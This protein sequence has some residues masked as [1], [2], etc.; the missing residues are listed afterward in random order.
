MDPTV[1]RRTW[2]LLEPRALGVRRFRCPA[3]GPSLLLR[4]AAEETAIRCLRCRAS[5][6]T[7]SLLAALVRHRL[8]GSRVHA[9]ETS[10]RGPLHRFLR[11]RCGHLTCSEFLPGVPGGQEID[12]VCCEDL[13][14]LSFVD[15]TFD[16][17]T[18]SEVFEHVADDGAAFAEVHRVLRPGGTLALT[19][20]FDAA[21]ATTER[22]RMTATGIE[23]RLPPAYHGDRIRGDLGV[24]VFRDYGHDLP[25][26]LL[27][28]GFRQVRIDLSTR[29]RWFGCGRAVVMASR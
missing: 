4:L 25:A 28:A 15:A 24:L 14:A 22:A 3:C 11:R 10:S 8:V 20:P 19:V 6:V 21:A 2:R 1:L 27:G 26:C 16:L 13:Q 12:G 17:V 5:A 23:H 18:A 9:Y 7:L 29:H